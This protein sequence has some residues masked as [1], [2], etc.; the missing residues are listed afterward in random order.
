MI[1]EFLRGAKELLRRDRVGIRPWGRYVILDHGDGFQVKRIEVDPGERISYQL[2]RHRS[3]R[4]IIVQGRA[5]V[6]IGDQ[7]HEHVLGSSCYIPVEFPHRIQNIG[8]DT[9]VFIE[10]QMGSKILE[11]DI[12]RLEDD[13]GRS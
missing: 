1:A 6:T 3:E 12:E 7:E 9:L 13:Y 11:S 4:W 2:H 8:T 10:V 5:M